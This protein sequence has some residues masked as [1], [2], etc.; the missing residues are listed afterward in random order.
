[1]KG[2]FLSEQKGITRA[3][4]HS[5][6]LITLRDF[7]LTPDRLHPATTYGYEPLSLTGHALVLKVVAYGTNGQVRRRKDENKAMLG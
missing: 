4:G 6:S 5:I 1:V 3:K 7:T 2:Y